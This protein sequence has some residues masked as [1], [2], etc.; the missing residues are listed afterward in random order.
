MRA[1][2]FI[3]VIL[4][5]WVACSDSS[6]VP[7]D[8]IAKEK[9]EKIL[10]D[11]VQADNFSSEYLKKDSARINVKQETMKLYDQIF[12]IHHISRQEFEKS[13]HFYLDHPD[14]TKV[15]FDSLSAKAN[16]QRNELH[17]RPGTPPSQLKTPP[18]FKPPAP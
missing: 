4:F 2:I 8:I 1:P 5:F 9:M 17:R 7:K 13:Y 6:A 14:I 16:R 12:L 11:I 10:W 3:V 15:M 18:Q